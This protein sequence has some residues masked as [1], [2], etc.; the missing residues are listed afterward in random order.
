M[1]MIRKRPPLR[2]GVATIE[3]LMI[4]PLFAVLFLMLYTI[5]A[6]GLEAFR[7]AVR[8]HNLAWQSQND[9][10]STQPLA[11]SITTSVTRKVP[12]IFNLDN[13]RPE[14]VSARA[15]AG[16]VQAKSEGCLEI[17]FANI[18]RQLP[19]ISRQHT[20][21]N[22]TWDDREL[23]FEKQSHHP[24]LG[25]ER[26]LNAFGVPDLAAFMVLLPSRCD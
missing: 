22:G 10:A 20:L 25:L 8:S 23:A 9:I 19:I 24:P 18:T 12:Q 15:R 6:G 21:L 4:L 7:V 26:R 14:L 13:S 2:D 16:K 3:M 5:A 17:G 1:H 11:F